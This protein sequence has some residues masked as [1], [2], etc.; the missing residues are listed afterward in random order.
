MNS[1]A[2][3]TA[4]EAILAGRTSLGIE[5]GSTRIK[6][7]LI[8]EDA[9]VL[10]VGGHEWENRFEDRVWTYSLEDVWT[11]LQRGVRRPGR[12]RRPAPR[13]APGDDRRDRR[14]RD[15]ARLPG[16]RR[17][18]P[19]ARA[20]PHVAQHHDRGRLGRAHRAVRRQH[21]AALVHRSPASGRA[22]RGTARPG[23][24]VPHDARRLRALA[25]D[26]PQSARGRR[27]VRHVP[28]RCGDEGLRR[29]AHRALRRAG[30]AARA[31]RH[32][33]AASGGARGRA[34]GRRAERRGGGPARPV[35]SAAPRHPVLP[36]GGR[37]RHRHGRDQCGRSAHRQRQRRHEHLRDG[38]ARAARSP[39]C[40]TSSTS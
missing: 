8:D 35:R 18:R 23:G 38:R 33:G 29:R 13:Y 31:G 39:R 25:A 14:L 20:V 27:R 24:A 22:R 1:P 40:I 10:A 16:L 32:R 36:A 15:D 19:A 34:A 21:S 3:D 11:G 28:D 9:E 26:G 37:C 17:G 2:A 7:C 30:R 6:A 4:R 12:R 5:L